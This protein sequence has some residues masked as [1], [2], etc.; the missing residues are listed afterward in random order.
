[1]LCYVDL[2]INHELPDV[3]WKIIGVAV[4]QHVC[5]RVHIVCRLRMAKWLCYTNDHNLYKGQ[6]CLRCLDM[7]VTNLKPSSPSHKYWKIFKWLLS[8]SHAWT[9]YLIIFS[10]IYISDIVKGLNLFV[11]VQHI[12]TCQMF[13]LQN[14]MSHIA[15]H[16]HLV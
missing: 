16:V 7:E 9:K 3:T 2:C 14:I 11:N 8:K 6:C 5:E 15:G 1:M 4:Y 10:H 13:F 12:W